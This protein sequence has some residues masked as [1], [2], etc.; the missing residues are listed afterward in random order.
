MPAAGA[1]EQEEADERKRADQITLQHI[2]AE[3][4]KQEK[5][6]EL[7]DKKNEELCLQIELIRL[8]RN[9]GKKTTDAK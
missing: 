2:E 6:I 8:Q 1:K 4:K 7:Q 9:E 3:L 5:I